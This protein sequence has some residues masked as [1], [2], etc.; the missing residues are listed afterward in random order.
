MIT[1]ALICFTSAGAS[2][3]ER[4]KARLDERYQLEGFVSSKFVGETNLQQYH[5]T[6]AQW[7]EE[8]FPKA[9][10]LIFVGAC[11]IAVRAIAPFVRD[12]FADPAV[13][14]I[15]ERANFCISLM[16]GHVG[17]ANDLTK[18]FAQLLDA[19]PVITTATDINSRFAVDVFAKRNDLWIASRNLAK[20]I[21]AA[22]LAGKPVSFHSEFPESGKMPRELTLQSDGQD[23]GIDVSFFNPVRDGVLWLA[24]KKLVLGIGCR[25][26]TPYQTIEDFIIPTLREHRLAIESVSAVASIDLKAEESGLLEF[27]A[28]HHLPFFTYSAQELKQATGDFSPSAFVQS[29]T[30]VDTVC[31][32]SAVLH[33]GGKLLLS[34][35]KGNGVTLA[36]A[37]NPEIITL[38]F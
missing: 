30:G 22:V 20:E 18:T 6:L 13:V 9:D 10:C 33:S 15:D 14:V 34:K 38:R 27:C 28:A 2:C 23:L 8:W 4:L 12:K 19:Q 37:A 24:P 21:S 31:E 26:G 16:S 36:V 5:G 35:Q 29:V 32:R 11:G 3:A 1:L 25:K 17:G 7:T